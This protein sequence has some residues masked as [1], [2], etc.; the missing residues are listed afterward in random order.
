M[1]TKVLLGLFLTSGLS[2]LAA[3]SAGCGSDGSNTTGGGGAGGEGPASSSSTTMPVVSS[4][5]TG[6]P[7][8]T[9]TSCDTAESIA[10]DVVAIPGALEP[11]FEDRDYYVF[12]GTKGLAIVLETDSK[13]QA[14]EFDQTYPDTV[15]TLKMRDAE[16]NWVDIAQNDDPYPLPTSSNDGLMYTVLPADGTYCVEVT[17]C[18]T[19]FG[20][21]NCRAAGAPDILVTDYTI[22]GGVLVTDPTVMG[23]ANETATEPSDDAGTIDYENVQMG[24]LYRS[25]VW[26]SFANETDKDMWS[27]TPPMELKVDAGS[28]AACHFEF[29][30]PGADGNGSS[31]D[32]NVTAY[33][34]DKADPTM[35][36][37]EI[38][39]NSYDTTFGRLEPM[40]I[41]VP[42][43][44]AKEY[45]FVMER[46]AGA[47]PGAND[48]Y[49]FNH[50]DLTANPVEVGPNDDIAA[51]EALKE[52]PNQSG[53]VSFFVDGDIDA[54]TD[55]DYYTVTVPAGST[56]VS[57]A[58][59]AERGGSAVRG[60]KV[61]AL[62]PNDMA[63]TGGKGNAT[64]AA[65]KQLFAYDLPV[66]MGVTSLKIKV[67]AS[68]V[69][70]TVLSKFYRCGFHVNPPAMP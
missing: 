61:S 68:A 69:E 29:Y 57:V 58:C 7:L 8:D 43:E 70:P 34:V 17:E 49:F 3:G 15:I 56:T 6:V 9:N 48:F 65:T 63:I 1:R 33:V 18:S 35:K 62:G 24:T 60:L 42:C 21:A 44:K 30:Y 54:V 13:P 19:L 16:G 55:V 67:E 45:L 41:S 59:E 38:N 10:L 31:A 50:Y 20:E 40:N 28:R 25:I 4:S 12:E 32:K 5:S 46:T 27:F 14:D 39:P 51:P 37:A 52:N 2:L 11:V 53:G 64:E 47:V 36:I 66:P 23:I 22:L 26:G